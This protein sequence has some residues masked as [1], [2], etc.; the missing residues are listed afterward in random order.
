MTFRHWAAGFIALG[1]LA[2]ATA[3]AATGL[4]SYEGSDYSR[5]NAG[6]SVT[7]CDLENDSRDVHADY[8]VVGSGSLRILDASG[9]SSCET[10][11][12][13]S[14]GIYQ[15]RAVEEISLSPDQFGPWRY[16]S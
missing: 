16:P 6:K 10:S 14:G 9:Y 2:P 11:G 4:Y 3:M 15:H 5:D 7:V 12:Y 1:V 13:Y 8:K